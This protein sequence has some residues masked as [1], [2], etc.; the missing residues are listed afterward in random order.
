M[1]GPATNSFWRAH[2]LTF[3]ARS[4][5]PIGEVKQSEVVMPSRRKKRNLSERTALNRSHWGVVRCY[6]RAQKPLSLSMSPATAIHPNRCAREQAS[7]GFSDLPR[8]RATISDMR[9]RSRTK[10]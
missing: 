6:H 5:L 8:S 9:Q 4:T 2:C 3:Q 1:F 7:R 10:G